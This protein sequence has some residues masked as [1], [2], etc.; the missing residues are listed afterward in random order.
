[1]KQSRG[2][3][4][5]IIVASIVLDD[6]RAGK[7]YNRSIFFDLCFCFCFVSLVVVVFLGA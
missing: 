6:D 2:G 5:H 3:G 4:P 1:M 7:I